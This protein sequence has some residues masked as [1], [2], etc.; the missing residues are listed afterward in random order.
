QTPSPTPISPTVQPTP[1]TTAIQDPNFPEVK[2]QPLPPMPDLHR[3]GIISSNVLP[4]SLNDTIRRAIQNNNDIEVARDDVRVAEQRLRALYGSYDP[5]FS[6]TPAIDERISPVTSIFAGG[7]TRGSVKNTT[8]NFSPSISKFF[9][10]GGGS[11][12][13]QF[14]NGRTS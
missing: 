14:N 9:E 8:L 12:Q 5:V 7:G 2:A 6:I 1:S 3:V 4:L 13:V 11:Y 10:K